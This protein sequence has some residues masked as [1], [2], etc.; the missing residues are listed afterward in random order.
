MKRNSVKAEKGE[1]PRKPPGDRSGLP[2]SGVGAFVL[3]FGV[4]MSAYYC[5]IL[6]P[7]VD[8]LLYSY[9]SANAWLANS[10]LRLFGADSAV[11]GVT[12]HSVAFTMNVRRG[13]DAIEPAWFF[14][15]AVIA[16]PSPWASKISGLAAGSAIILTLNLAR[17][18]SLYWLG[19][20]FPRVFAAAHLEI[21]PVLFILV[22]G[23]LFLGWIGLCR[24]AS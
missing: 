19:A 21:W 10:V 15:A 9:L 1:D 14:C 16:F 7:S 3:K 17:L 22:A 18:V 4:L 5:I 8:H 13:C 24:R 20:N 11:S 23:L 2:K 6:L 12:I